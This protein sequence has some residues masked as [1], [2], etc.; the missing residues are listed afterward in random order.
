M[1]G[2]I[3]IVSVNDST[4]LDHVFTA[5]PDGVPTSIENMANLGGILYADDEVTVIRDADMT[6]TCDDEDQDRELHGTGNLWGDP[7]NVYYY[8]FNYIFK[9]AGEHTITFTSGDLT[10]T[11]TLKAE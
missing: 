9:E 8:P 11:V 4:P 6:I 1:S 10:A 3:E 5:V 2:R 7:H